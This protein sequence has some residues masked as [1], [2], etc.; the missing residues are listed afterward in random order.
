MSK[1]I[2]YL[3]A[4]LLA[5]AGALLLA[6]GLHRPVRLQ[7]NDQPPIWVDTYALTSGGALADAA[8]AL[9]PGD[10]IS[11]APEESIG[12]QAAIQIRRPTRVDLYLPD[13]KG[14]TPIIGSQTIPGILLEKA[15]IALFP[16]DRVLRNG[17]EIPLG[18]PL[19]D[20][21]QVTLQYQPAHAVSVVQNGR[22]SL[23]YTAGST[24]ARA[25]W[26]LGLRPSPF[27]FYSAPLNSPLESQASI[28]IQAARPISVQVDGALVHAHSAAA[29]TGQ[30]LAEIGL[31]LQGLDQSIPA[32]GQPVPQDGKVQVVRVREENLFSQVSI[33]FKSETVGDP[34]LELDQ[35][36]I[37]QVGQAGAK[38]TRQRVRYE[39]GKETSRQTEAEWIASQPRSQKVAFGT[40][41][42]YKTIETSDGTVQYYRAVRVYATSF[43]PCKFI[44][45]IGKCSY[46]TANG[47]T[48]QKGVI[49]MGEGWYRLFANQKVYVEG[50]GF[51]TVAD[52]GYVPG[53]WIDLGYSDADFVNWHGY[54][55]L[56]FLAPA[57]ANV[58]VVLPK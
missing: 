22:S 29:T 42:A 11:P 17:I 43:A 9:F 26:D 7:I 34:T 36:R 5:G 39:D 49:G 1:K 35:T 32:E 8:I 30:A 3:G 28:A 14:P 51:A 23:V 53:Y 10:V 58:P 12:W 47:M 52:Y 16:G 6:L 40:Q 2:G 4:A 38:V 24:Y 31:A 54:T 18:L 56:Y 21:A 37:A 19:K 55:T 48:L 44:P 50:Y 41:V 20:A 25:L 27:D 45:F 57:P 13:Q 33:P 46:S 15:G